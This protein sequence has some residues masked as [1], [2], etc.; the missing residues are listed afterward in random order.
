MYLANSKYTMVDNYLLN[1]SIK[2][3][4]NIYENIKKY[5]NV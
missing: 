3:L 1:V 5:G 2:R 4:A